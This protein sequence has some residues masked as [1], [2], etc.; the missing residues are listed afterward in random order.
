MPPAK[1]PTQFRPERACARARER[2]GQGGREGGREG[3]RTR[4][5]KRA[6]AREREREKGSTDRLP[7]PT[8]ITV[9]PEIECK[10]HCHITLLSVT[11]SP[12]AR[13]TASRFSP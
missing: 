4:E 13:R 3:A 2:E 9:I 5:R 11:L 6:R 12:L 8:Q 10:T 1:R 7:V